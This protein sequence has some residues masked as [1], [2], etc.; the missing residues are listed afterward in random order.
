LGL[1]T[2]FKC[3]TSN[4]GSPSK[5]GYQKLEPPKPEEAVVVGIN[6]EIL[7]ILGVND[8]VREVGRA[9][10]QA[11]VAGILRDPGYPWSQ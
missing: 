6:I 5:T 8:K 1:I 11:M 9:G 2:F 10:K 4:K 7:D 3:I